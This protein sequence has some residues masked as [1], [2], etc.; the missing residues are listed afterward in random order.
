MLITN[1][2]WHL[3]LAARLLNISDAPNSTQ[4]ALETVRRLSNLLKE[5]MEMLSYRCQEMNLTANM[6]LTVAVQPDKPDNYLEISAIS[7]KIII[8]ANFFLKE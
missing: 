1:S 5:I 3:Y 4:E 2:N 6:N 8:K 7:G